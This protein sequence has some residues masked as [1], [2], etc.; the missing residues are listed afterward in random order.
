MG[1]EVWDSLWSNRAF[2]VHT[3][4]IYPKG[5][6]DY[7]PMTETR[8]RCNECRFPFA[9]TSHEEVSAGYCN[10]TDEL[11][12]AMAVIARLRSELDAAKHLP[13]KFEEEND[14]D[15]EEEPGYPARPPRGGHPMQPIVLDQNG[16][17]RF[18][19]NQIV[20]FLVHHGGFNLNQIAAMPWPKEDYEQLMQLI[21]TS[22][23]AIGANTEFVSAELVAEAD[24][25]AETLL[26]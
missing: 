6:I 11:R 19:Q 15:F 2:G 13:D 25:I 4:M 5:G 12:C 17:P 26:K 3:H 1:L 16:T 23:S 8:P 14:P 7:E 9:R 24:G 21:G 22:V 20:Y 18:K 10:G